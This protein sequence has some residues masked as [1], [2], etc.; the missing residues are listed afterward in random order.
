MLSKWLNVRHKVEIGHYFFSNNPN[1]QKK[2]L[3]PT[4]I[5]LHFSI[6]AY[7]SNSLFFHSLSNTCFN[8]WQV[9]IPL[10]TPPTYL[11]I[12]FYN[13]IRK[14]TPKAMLSISLFFFQHHQRQMLVIW[15]QTFLP[16]FAWLQR[17]TKQQS[18]KMV[19]DMKMH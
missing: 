4:W 17:T 16:I 10:P 11:E 12:H 19:S 7:K 3:K 9:I 1:Q 14:F 18:G 6:E 5:C 15:Q 2:M 8:S 13:K